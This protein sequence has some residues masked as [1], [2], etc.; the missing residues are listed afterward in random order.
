[1]LGR[2][3]SVVKDVAELNLSIN[4]IWEQF[5]A[6]AKLEKTVEVKAGI[7]KSEGVTFLGKEERCAN[8]RKGPTY[9]SNVRD[10]GRFMV[11]NSDQ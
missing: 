5:P 11:S 9:L 6:P 10:L 3:V 7:V 4:E 1:M 2:V 8:Q